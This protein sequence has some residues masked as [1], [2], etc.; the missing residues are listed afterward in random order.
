MLSNTEIT[1]A[2][3]SNVF[4]KVIGFVELKM[5]NIHNSFIC[6]KNVLTC[7]NRKENICGAQVLWLQPYF[8]YL[9]DIFNVQF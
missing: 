4:E 5:M 9:C 7:L 1:S 3:C 2:V 8:F 6:V